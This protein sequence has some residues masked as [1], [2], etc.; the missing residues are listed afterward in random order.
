MCRWV[1]VAPPPPL[2]TYMGV[3][4]LTVIQPPGKGVVTV[5]DSHGV[6]IVF[7][8]VTV[9]CRV[10]LHDATL[11]AQ[12]TRQRGHCHPCWALFWP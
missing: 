3:S 6:M 1:V 4:L 8:A 12:T 11:G 5:P 10:Q 7:G 2:P 9:C